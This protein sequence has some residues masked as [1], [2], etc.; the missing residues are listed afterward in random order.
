MQAQHT[1]AAMSMAEAAII[2]ERLRAILEKQSVV[3]VFVAEGLGVA[4]LAAET[5]PQDSARRTG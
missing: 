3:N 2:N 1:A 5:L 4:E